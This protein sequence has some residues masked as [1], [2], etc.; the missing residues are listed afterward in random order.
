MLYTDVNAQEGNQ[1][2]LSPPI[3]EEFPVIQ[4]FLDVRDQ[5]GSFVY[6]L[7]AED[8]A[9]LENENSIP[10]SELDHLQPGTQVVFQVVL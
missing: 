1:A 9:V 7:K 10:V 6:G 3:T 4:A 8:V 2:Y 5:E